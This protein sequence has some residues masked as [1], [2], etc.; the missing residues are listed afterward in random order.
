MEVVVALFIF[1]CITS[2]IFNLMH[3]TDKLYGRAV[4][5]EL[6][7]R[8]ASDEAERLRNI[9]F[10][11][12][13]FEDSTYS[14]SISGRSFTI[15]RKIIVKDNPQNLENKTLEPAEIEISVRDG[16]LETVT[17]LTFKLLMGNDAP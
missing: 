16:R 6:A 5:V 15:S 13:V 8:I 14:M 1:G 3:Q 12:G 10:Q 2:A 17:P 11:N 7:S 9:A 4:F